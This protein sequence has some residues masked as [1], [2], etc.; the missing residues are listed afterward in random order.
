MVLPGNSSVTKLPV[1]RPSG[2]EYPEDPGAAQ[3]SSAAFFFRITRLAVKTRSRLASL[4]KHA[5]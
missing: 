2:M 4:P 3:R 5:T 1:P